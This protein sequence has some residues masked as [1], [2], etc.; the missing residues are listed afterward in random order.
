M[1]ETSLRDFLFFHCHNTVTKNK[2]SGFPEVLVQLF[3]IQIKC[4]SK[5]DLADKLLRPLLVMKRF[6]NSSLFK[7]MDILNFLNRSR[8][9]FMF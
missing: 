4:H 5:L 3:Q 9:Q 7:F 2:R 8:I 6:K 1:N